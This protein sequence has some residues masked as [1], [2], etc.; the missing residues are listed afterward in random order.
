[1]KYTVGELTMCWLLS[2]LTA[3][4][5]QQMLIGAFGYLTG[6]DGMF[7]FVKPG[8]SYEG[9]NFLGMRVVWLQYF[10]RILLLQSVFY[11]T[12]SC[13]AIFLPKL[14]YVQVYM[15]ILFHIKCTG[16]LWKENDDSRKTAFC[17][18]VD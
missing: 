4:F 13:P 7:P 12:F 11:S 18:F 2:E 6:Y 5:P 14:F 1:M 3:S 15:I 16:S 10:E 17:K 9:V 8:D